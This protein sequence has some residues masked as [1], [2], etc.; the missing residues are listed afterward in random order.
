MGTQQPD[1]L[2]GISFSSAEA[3]TSG[4]ASTS[5]AQTAGLPRL[6]NPSLPMPRVI[7]GQGKKIRRDPIDLEAAIKEVKVSGTPCTQV[8]FCQA[9]E[10]QERLVTCMTK[11]HCGRSRAPFAPHNVIFLF[12]VS[13]N[14]ITIACL[15]CWLMALQASVKCKFDESVEVH[16]RLGTDPRRGD[17]QVRG[18]TVL[19]FGTGKAV[20]V[21]VFAEGEAAEAA[22]KAGEYGFAPLEWLTVQRHHKHSCNGSPSGVIESADAALIPCWQRLRI[23]H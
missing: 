22:R 6:N 21:C 14:G 4:Q 10:S 23:V 12:L 19:P 15:T 13:L 3:R 9:S 7:T 11:N 16:I 8:V 17:Q 2:P 20:R 5:Q 18:A 1:G